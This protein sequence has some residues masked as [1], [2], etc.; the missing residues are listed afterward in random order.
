M[1]SVVSVGGGKLE[2]HEP[3]LL[4]ALACTTLLCAAIVIFPMAI[5]SG[6][7]SP[8]LVQFGEDPKKALAAA[9]RKQL[10]KLHLQAAISQ[11]FG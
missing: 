3:R 8:L 10:M 7:D 6:F 11:N 5:P 2:H 9:Q 4:L 1:S